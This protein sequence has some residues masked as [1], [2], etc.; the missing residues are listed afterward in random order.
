M[1]Y[2]FY[3]HLNSGLSI[4]KCLLF[5]SWN[6]LVDIAF[7]NMSTNYS[8]EETYMTSNLSTITSSLTN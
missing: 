1:L 8:C 3:S 5:N 6:L 4:T 2:S 7:V